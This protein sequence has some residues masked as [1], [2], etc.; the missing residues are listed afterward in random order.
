MND[1]HL[2]IGLAV[3]CATA[4]GTVNGATIVAALNHGYSN[5]IPILLSI[6]VTL[7]VVAFRAGRDAIRD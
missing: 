2:A 5:A 6:G 3:G 1:K 7:L 4:G